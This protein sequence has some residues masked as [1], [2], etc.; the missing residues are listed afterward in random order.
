MRL[1]GKHL[2]A[3]VAD[4]CVGVQEG[5]EVDETGWQTTDSISCHEISEVL[6]TWGSDK[7]LVR[8]D[9]KQW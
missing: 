2:I 7:L 8:D 4:G 1:G 3:S 6:W 5:S 9:C